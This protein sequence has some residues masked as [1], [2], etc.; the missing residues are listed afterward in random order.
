VPS[1]FCEEWVVSSRTEPGERDKNTT[2]DAVFRLKR[3]VQGEQTALVESRE[4][5]SVDGRAATA[6]PDD[7]PAVLS[8]LFEGGLAVASVSQASCMNYKLERSKPGEPIVVRFKTFLTPESTDECFLDE[9]STGRVVID[10]VTMQVKRLE[11]TTPRHTVVDAESFRPAENGRRELTVDYGT[12]VFDGASYWMPAT[13]T[14]RITIGSAF[15][16]SVWSYRA[17]YRDFHELEVTSRIH[18]GPQ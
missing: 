5:K 1:F 12:V 18:E 4:V 10:P 7:E 16:Q 13:I 3:T 9:K 15:D 17:S 6:A 8:G 2:T 14:M 11:I